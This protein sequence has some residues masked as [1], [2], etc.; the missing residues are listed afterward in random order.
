VTC[1]AGGRRI[2]KHR[3]PLK[4]TPVDLIRSAAKL[5]QERLSDEVPIDIYVP[6]AMLLT[7]ENRKKFADL[8]SVYFVA[9]GMQ[10]QVN[11]V[12]LEILKKAYE[13]PEEHPHVIV[14]KGSF[15]LY[16]TDMLREVQVDMIALFERE[17]TG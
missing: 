2:R 14:R 15:S 9:G 7:A 11:S 5:P 16:F 6:A 8:L 12:N 13:K 1:A 4:N 17:Y 10:V 3:L